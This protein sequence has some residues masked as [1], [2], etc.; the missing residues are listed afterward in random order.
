MSYKNTYVGLLV[1]HLLSFFHR[2]NVTSLSFF[3]CYY[4]GICFTELA[5]LLLLPFS[6]RRYMHYF[7]RLYDVSVAL[8][9]CDINFYVNIVFLRAA[10]L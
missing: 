8:P 3:C 6:V 4:F 5:E 10:R 9:R 1:Q 2:R 7:D